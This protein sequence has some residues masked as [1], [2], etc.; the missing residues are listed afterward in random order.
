MK[1]I[2][3][4]LLQLLEHHYTTREIHGLAFTK[5]KNSGLNDI[6]TAGH[7]WSTGFRIVPKKKLHSPETEQ[8]NKIRIRNQL[9]SFTNTRVTPRS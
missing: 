8:T 5:C 4:V 9:Y 1:Q 7:Q 3:N 6:Q 2:V